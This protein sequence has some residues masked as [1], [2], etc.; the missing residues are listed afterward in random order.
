MGKITGNRNS[1]SNNSI[2]LA[3]FILFYEKVDQT[4]ECIKSFLP[5][6]INIYILNNGSSVS[7][8]LKL[9]NFC[10][11]F[12]QI[13]IFDSDVNLGVSGGRNYLIANTTEGWIFSVDNDLTVNTADWLEKFRKHVS[14][15]SEIEV[16]IPKMF[17]VH[18]NMYSRPY[19][20]IVYENMA[21]LDLSSSDDYVNTFFG[22]ASFICRKMFDRLGCY[23][24]VMF[25]GMEDFELC[26]RG[27]LSKNPVKAKLVYD[28]ELIHD[29]R[30]ATTI[31]DK[32][33]AM[34]RYNPDIINDSH[35]RIT[36]KHNV[37]FMNYS[38]IHANYHLEHMLNASNPLTLYF[39]KKLLPKPIKTA[40]R[41]FGENIRGRISPTSATLLMVDASDFKEP[42]CCR[43]KCTINKSKTMT[44]P[45][46]QRLLS[47]YPSINSFCIGRFEESTLCPNFISIVDFLKKNGREVKIETSGVNIEKLM[48]LTYEPDCITIN[49]Y[50]PNN[51]KYHDHPGAD[52]FDKVVD[53]FQVLKNRYKNVGF[54]Y[55]VNKTNYRTLNNF[56]DLCD[57]LQPSFLYLHNYLAC[58]FDNSTEVAKAITSKDS[59]ALNYIDL[60]VKGRNYS[61]SK[62]VALDTDRPKEYC[63]SYD[64]LINVDSC[65]NI[66]GCQQLIRPNNLFGNIFTDDDPFNS[67]EM[68]K[69]RRNMHKMNYAH[70]R[71]PF[72]FDTCRKKKSEK[73]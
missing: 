66:S 53:N 9:G 16:F 20:F 51:V 5:S 14:I 28:I 35:R 10:S 6:C 38:K 46:V 43:E 63:R 42:V 26:L 31:N 15:N 18:N 45:V 19:S 68:I 4:I 48:A 59:D 33:S 39:W 60:I 2:D 67:S 1:L 52:A 71:C 3:V 17:N 36:D 24:E 13:K 12:R 64:Y 21:F 47:L 25:V 23:D 73:I 54:T 61:I 22:G 7:G 30:A 40:I 55:M 27:V 32:K 44:L 70:K 62:P 58:D 8:R 34:I 72:C 29:H 69:L 50:D 56:L 65:G 57:E 37:I 49:F 11:Q 41:C